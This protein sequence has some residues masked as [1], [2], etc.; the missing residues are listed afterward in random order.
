MANVLGKE[1]A[2]GQVY[3]VQVGVATERYTVG[4]ISYIDDELMIS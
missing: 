4:S 1:K 2:K 3:N